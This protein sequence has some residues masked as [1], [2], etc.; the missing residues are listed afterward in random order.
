MAL[1]VEDLRNRLGGDALGEEINTLIEKKL[2][3]I[4]NDGSQESRDIPSQKKAPGKTQPAKPARAPK[5]D[6]DGKRK[7][8]A[9]EAIFS[10]GDN[11]DE[12]YMILS[13]LVEISVQ[14]DGSKL[15]LAKLDRGEIFGEMALIDDQPRMAAARAM[16]DT[17]VV[18]V[19]QESFKKRLS[20]LSEEDRLISHI[21]DALVSRLRQQPFAQ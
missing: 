8:L 2:A 13:G 18:V 6:A 11:G 3:K 7:F 4:L 10:E 17:E 19:P 5:P 9:G 20:W 14:A 15:V 21:L 1:A 12:A 16:T